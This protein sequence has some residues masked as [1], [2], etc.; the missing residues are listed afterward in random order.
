MT[1]AELENADVNYHQRVAKANAAQRAGLFVDAIDLAKSSW[2]Y[3][4]GMIQYARK[5]EMRESLTLEGIELVLKLAP[6]VFDLSSLESLESL[7]KSQRRIAKTSSRDLEVGLQESRAR[8]SIAYR[9][10]DRMERNGE[11][12]LDEESLADREQAQEIIDFWDSHEFVSRIPSRTSTRACLATRMDGL[13]FAKCPSCGAVV[14]IPKNQCLAKSE[15][16]ACCVEVN[17]VLLNRN[18]SGR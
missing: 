2:P 4:D 12:N 6:F 18:L 3:I 14:R 15:C 8:L 10:W 7:L 17:L 13:T 5:Y 9:M 1:K 11:L 16:S